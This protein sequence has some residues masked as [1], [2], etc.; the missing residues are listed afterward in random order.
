VARKAAANDTNVDMLTVTDF[1]NDA[2]SRILNSLEQVSSII[3]L[4][5]T[6]KL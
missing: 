1:Y 4:N 5:F 2:T 3:N 6:P